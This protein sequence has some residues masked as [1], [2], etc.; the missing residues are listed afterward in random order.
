MESV[1][2]KSGREIPCRLLLC[3]TGVTPDLS[4]IQDTPI[5]AR[6]GILVDAMMETNVP[7]IFAA[8][9]VMEG[10]DDAGHPLY[11]PN[12]INAVKGGRVAGINMAGG[13]L[14]FTGLVNSHVVRIFGTPLFSFGEKDPLEG[15][16]LLE[17]R[18][19]PRSARRL[20][21]RQGRIAGFQ[22]M[23]SFRKTGLLMGLMR[24]GADVSSFGDSLLNDDFNYGRLLSST[25]KYERE[26]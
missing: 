8:G 9:D 21:L 13:S 18:M 25:M 7:G 20:I 17:R 14:P 1:F 4:L 6:R 22:S 2:T 16:T 3:A 12:W 15:D 23:G 5:A 19:N 24:K 11:A 10:R 26:S